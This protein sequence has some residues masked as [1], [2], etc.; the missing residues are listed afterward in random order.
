MQLK[1]K[2]IYITGGTGGIGT[3][4][5]SLLRQSGAEVTVYDIQKD[6]DLVANLDKTCAALSLNAPDILINMALSLL[7]QSRGLCEVDCFNWIVFSV[8]S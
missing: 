1:G 6:G 2:R 8:Q 3:P 5:V 4:L 7:V